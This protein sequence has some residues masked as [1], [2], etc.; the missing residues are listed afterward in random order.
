[1]TVASR[2]HPPGLR[3]M[4]WSSC[5]VEAYRAVSCAHNAPRM[6]VA[7][8]AAVMAQS[9]SRHPRPNQAG[10]AADPLPLS[11]AAHGIGTGGR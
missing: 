3:S 5:K 10:L 6:L 7:G 11:Q 9:S 4:G 2:T 8:P 1:M